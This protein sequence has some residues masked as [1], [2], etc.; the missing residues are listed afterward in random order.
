MPEEFMGCSRKCNGDGWDDHITVTMY[1]MGMYS[2]NHYSQ[3]LTI[4]DA[5]KLRD[6]LTALIEKNKEN[7]IIVAK[8]Y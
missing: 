4:K 7:P 1:N 8:E 6:Q 3:C 2:E 5:T